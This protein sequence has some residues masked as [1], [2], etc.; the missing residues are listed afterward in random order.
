MISSIGAKIWNRTLFFMHE[1]DGSKFLL[2]MNSYE[3]LS[4]LV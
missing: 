2:I 1:A 3:T 4:Y